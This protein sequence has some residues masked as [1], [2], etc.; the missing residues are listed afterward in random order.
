M[1]TL[2]A[3]VIGTDNQE[4]DTSANIVLARFNFYLTDAKERIAIKCVLN[5]FLSILVRLVYVYYTVY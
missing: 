5:G 2:T 3:L 4:T 1:F